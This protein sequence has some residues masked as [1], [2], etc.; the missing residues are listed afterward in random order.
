MNIIYINNKTMTILIHKFGNCKYETHKMMM[1][2]HR[3]MNKVE[4]LRPREGRK[5]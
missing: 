4:C 2:D 1:R 3:T 5:K